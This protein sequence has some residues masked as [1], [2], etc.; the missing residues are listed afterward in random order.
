MDGR[1]SVQPKGKTM[2]L[3]ARILA[4]TAILLL[5][6]AAAWAGQ[7]TRAQQGAAAKGVAGERPAGRRPSK[8]DLN[9]AP[10]ADLQDLP[11]IDSATANRIAKGRPYS[12]VDDLA[13]VGVPAATIARIRPLVTVTGS[14]GGSAGTLATETDAPPAAPSNPPG[15]A[16]N[17]TEPDR[18]R[19]PG[20]AAR[21]A[22]AVWVIPGARVFVRAGDARYGKTAH[23]RYM[24]EQDA[25]KEGYREA[26]GVKKQ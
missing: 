21:A 17:P 14:G 1:R 10:Q 3:A 19:E 16:A 11:G 18:A 5:G 12:T 9:T 2:R 24:S 22:A 15:S 7:A 26:P 23:G 8:I 4:V 6:A 25:L 20:N 13:H